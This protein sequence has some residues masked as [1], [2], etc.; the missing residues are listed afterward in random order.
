MASFVE[1]LRSRFEEL[2]GN[3]SGRDR[4]LLGGMTALMVVFLLGGSTWYARKTLNDLQSR[5][6]DKQQKLAMI[7]SLEEG[8]QQSASEFARIE[9]KM[10]QAS[11]QDLPAFIEHAAQKAQVA[12]NLQSVREKNATTEG[13]LEEKTYQVEV[14]KV[15]LDQLTNF[16]YE[17]ETGGY[18]LK[19]RSSKTKVSGGG[20]TKVLNLSLELSAYRLQEDAS[21]TTEEKKP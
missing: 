13:N 19:I 18:P 11:G 5:V 16:L 3:L 8:Q 20:G 14:A 21:A 17:V 4:Q 12:P 1:P 2:I 6:A 10:R 7:K 15:T 9:E